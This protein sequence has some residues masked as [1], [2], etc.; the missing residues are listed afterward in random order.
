MIQCP[1]CGRETPPGGYCIHCGTHLAH[2]NRAHN[3]SRTHAYA[4]NPH[5]PVSHLSVVSTL[6]PHLGPTHTHR[7][8][9]LLL[10]LA[11]IIFLVGLGRLVPLAIVLSAL[12][13]PLL[14]LFYFFD[15]LIFEEEPLPVILLTFGAGALLGIG[16]SLV[17]FRVVL[18]NTYFSLSGQNT[19]HVLITGVVLPLLAQALM[20]VGPVILFLVRPRFD[21]VLDG[22]VFGAASGLGFAAAQSIIYS[23]LIITGPFARSGPAYS[24]A[25]LTIQDAILIPLLYAATTGLICASL[26]L[27]RDRTE[28]AGRNGLLAFPLALLI[29]AL[30]IVIPSVGANLLGGNILNLVWYAVVIA[31]L[32]LLLRRILHTG[33][34]EKAR[35]L[36]TGGEIECPHCH[37]IVPDAAFCQHCGIALRSIARRD[38]RTAASEGTT[39]A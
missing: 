29:G 5:E 21:E 30:G 1:V 15:A 26:W 11:A 37:H 8:R 31:I 16:M 27:A 23:W 28:R 39:H 2:G 6:F 10:I 25:L 32:L 17:F 7:M 34:I 18:G 4:A 14:Y 22:L 13:V 3:A 36:A 35:T 9:W 38:R 12:L 24:W 33:L 20:L 19:S